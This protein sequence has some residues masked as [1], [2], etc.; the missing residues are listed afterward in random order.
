MAVVC[1]RS[2]L[3]RYAFSSFPAYCFDTAAILC[4]CIYQLCANATSPLPLNAILLLLSDR[5]SYLWRR[6]GRLSGYL[7]CSLAPPCASSLPAGTYNIRSRACTGSVQRLV[8]LRLSE[9]AAFLSQAPKKTKERYSGT[10]VSSNGE[11]LEAGLSCDEDACCLGDTSIR[12]AVLES[13]ELKLAKLSPEFIDEF[14][15]YGRQQAVL[16]QLQAPES[17]G[18]ADRSLLASSLRKLRK[19]PQDRYVLMDLYEWLAAALTFVQ[20]QSRLRTDSCLPAEAPAAR[21]RTPVKRTEG[22]RSASSSSRPV[23][24]ARS[25]SRKCGGCE[26]DEGRMRRGDATPGF[27]GRRSE[28]VPGRRRNVSG[29]STCIGMSLCRGAGGFSGA[30][31]RRPGCAE[32]VQCVTNEGD[33]RRLRG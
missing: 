28:N 23:P 9:T 26:E 1:R 8:P 22:G 32:E 11:R 31:E 24:L 21:G 17:G 15:L 19:Q 18:A 20:R 6:M 29:G 10:Q 33:T 12:A 3:Y 14:V 7:V 5:Q 27:G 25:L 16:M 13:I 2:A 30:F 4:R